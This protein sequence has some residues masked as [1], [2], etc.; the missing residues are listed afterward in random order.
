[1][2]RG[3]RVIKSNREKEIAKCYFE[4]LPIERATKK[5]NQKED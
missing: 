2:Q 1:M 4:H 5:R 3:L